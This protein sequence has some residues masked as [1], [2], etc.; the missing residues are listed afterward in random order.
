[1]KLNHLMIAGALSLFSMIASAAEPL[2]TF[3]CTGNTG[4]SPMAEALAS[5]LIKKD[6]LNVLVQ[7]RGVNVDPKE[8]TP[9]KGT[10]TVLKERGIDISHHQATQLTQADVDTSTLLL[11]MTQGHKDKILANFPAAKG[12]VYTLA[13]F[14]ANRQE[15]LSDPY[16]KPLEAYRTVEKQLDELLPLALKKIAQDKK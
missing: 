10:V 11:T 3:V 15:D 9:E 6:G 1:M 12:K 16:G 7:S 13:E 4:R 14:A 8:T 5:D 2:V